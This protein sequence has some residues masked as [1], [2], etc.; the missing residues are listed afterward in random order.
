MLLVHVQHIALQGST[1]NAVSFCSGVLLLAPASEYSTP[2]RRIHGWGSSSSHSGSSADYELHQSTDSVRCTDGARS[3]QE[4]VRGS[5]KVVQLPGRP[6][7]T[8]PVGLTGEGLMT[9]LH[10]MDPAWLRAVADTVAQKQHKESAG[11]TES[12]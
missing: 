2:S 3:R 11:K 4:P 10:E 5:S 8:L 1:D 12:E 7:A 9:V 6:G